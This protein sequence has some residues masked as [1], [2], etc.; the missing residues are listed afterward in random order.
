MKS[1]RKQYGTRLTEALQYA[2]LEA[3]TAE[4]SPGKSVSKADIT[5]K[6]I[7]LYL[8][9]YHPTIDLETK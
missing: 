8:T 3:V 5:E 9:T 6:A 1:K 4:S 2:V 7:T